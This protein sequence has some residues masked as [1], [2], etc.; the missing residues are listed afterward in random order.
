M[1]RVPGWFLVILV[2]AAVAATPARAQSSNGFSSLTHSVSVTLAPRVKVKVSAASM[3][4]SRHASLALSVV[5]NRSWVLASSDAVL[6]SGTASSAVDTKVM[7]GKAAKSPP[8]GAD[9]PI[10]LTLSAP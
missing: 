9:D 8:S 10:L 7:L 2:G 6:A 3:T 4:T 1:A 5:A